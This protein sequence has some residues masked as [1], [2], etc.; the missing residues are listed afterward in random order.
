MKLA[1]I[2]VGLLMTTGAVA[3]HA[4][5]QAALRPGE[6]R[7][8]RPRE[9][10]DGPLEAC[11]APVPCDQGSYDRLRAAAR[12]DEAF[13]EAI[14]ALRRRGPGGRCGFGNRGGGAEGQRR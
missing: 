5:Q 1:S 12:S 3:G 9:A 6:A 2:A 8:L 7:V 4:E 10:C 11:L 14:A 13:Q